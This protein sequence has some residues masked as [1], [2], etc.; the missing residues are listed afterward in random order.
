MDNLVYIHKN[1]SNTVYGPYRL[2]QP[3]TGIEK[4]QAVAPG[5]LGEAFPVESVEYEI[6]GNGVVTRIFVANHPVPRG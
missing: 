4:G 5:G 2:P 1:G 6:S 3:L